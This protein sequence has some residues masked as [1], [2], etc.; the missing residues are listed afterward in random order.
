MPSV[1]TASPAVRLAC[2]VLFLATLVLFSRAL[3]CDFLD[4]D[5]PDF[6]TQ[7]PAVQAGLSWQTV[8]EAFTTSDAGNWYPITRLSHVVAWQFLGAHPRGHHAI[9]V[10]LHAGSAVLAFLTLRRL[11]ASFWRSATC[12][13]LFAWHPLRVESVAWIAERKDVL[14]VFFGLLSLL[15]YA[16]YALSLT[17]RRTSRIGLYLLSLISY[18]LSLLSKPMLVTLPF[19]LL[20]LDAWPLQR[21][22][23]VQT[24]TN[25]ESANDQRSIIQLLVEKVPFIFAAL[26]SCVVT[27]VVQQNDGGIT[28]AF[29]LGSRVENAVVSIGRYLQKFTW[30][31]D[32]AAPYAHPEHWPIGTI[33]VSAA[34]LASLL[35]IA[36]LC[37]RKRPWILVGITWFLATLIPVLGL[38]QSGLQAMADRYSYI[39]SLGLGIALVWTI[40]DLLNTSKHRFAI[41]ATMATIT[42]LLLGCWTWKQTAYWSNSQRLFE[43]TLLLNENNYLAHTYLGTTL[44]NAGRLDEAARHYQRAIELS[45]TY[46]AAHFGLGSVLE[47][48]G[49]RTQALDYYQKAVTLRPNYPQALFGLGLTLLKDGRPAEAFSQFSSAAKYDP[50]SS[51]AERGL[52]LAEMELNHLPEAIRHFKRALAL[53]PRSS[54][55]LRDLGRAYMAAGQPHEAA[56]FLLHATEKVLADPNLY[57]DL[58]V[59]LEAENRNSEAEAA[60]AKSLQLNPRSAEAHYNLGVLMLNRDDLDS[61]KAH[62]RMAAQSHPDFGLAF[63]GLGIVHAQQGHGED[64]VI[65]LRKALAL[66]P[67]HAETHNA[68][69]FALSQLGSNSEALTHWEIAYKL[70]PSISGLADNISKARAA[71]AEKPQ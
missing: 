50:R 30:P 57:F 62:F 23:P 21:W 55:I 65:N 29:S 24:T 41:G 43:H 18:V 37:H 25:N 32:L 71:V 15:A 36:A 40:N 44:A 19:V 39:P 27:F 11:T 60:Y 47:K 22:A 70:D 5:D 49:N 46:A 20:L 9:N 42:L 1:R 69:G 53:N 66:M 67:N 3:T 35:I 13:A 26:A 45:P 12:A 31:V 2:V 58:G 52:G 56:E 63:F 6:L 16:N 7:N 34:V 14:S 8:G 33:V 61:A 4:Y 59:A 48:R 17:D 28:N 51:H 10:I 68:L 54:V 64:A 38:L